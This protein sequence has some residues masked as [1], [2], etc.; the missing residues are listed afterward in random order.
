MVQL[1]S[2]QPEA[3]PCMCS[4]YGRGGGKWDAVAGGGFG[5]W[6]R[7]VQPNHQA[8]RS[9]DWHARRRTLEKERKRKAPTAAHGLRRAFLWGLVHRIGCAV[10]LDACSRP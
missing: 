9:S 8:W 6:S 3:M 7:L 10:I 5:Q 1:S 2:S 4:A